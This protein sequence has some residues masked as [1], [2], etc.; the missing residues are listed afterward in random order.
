LALLTLLLGIRL[1]RLSRKES[2]S[3]STLLLA[4]LGVP[5][6]SG[7]R[8]FHIRLIRG[9]VRATTEGDAL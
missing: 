7:N 9:L 6:G 3:A 4:E 2:R 5:A 1:P 8:K